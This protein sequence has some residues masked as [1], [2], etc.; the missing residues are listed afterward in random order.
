MGGVLP[1]ESAHRVR[2]P[3]RAALHHRQIAP[4]AHQGVPLI[5]KGPL[6]FLV[7]GEEEHAGGVPIQPVDDEHPAPGVALPHVVGGHAVGGAQLF[8]VAGHAQQPGG[9]VHHQDPAV[10]IE[11]WEG[12][13]G[14]GRGQH[15]HPLP[16]RQGMV[17]AGNRFPVHR[18]LAP[19]EQGLDVVAAPP[20]PLQQEGQQGAARL[21]RIFH[22]LHPYHILGGILS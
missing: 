20:D 12:G 18:H 6:G 10:L 5:L 7:P 9:L 4:A 19:G 14:P 8:P 2:L 17:V 11:H 22:F 1:Q 16:R 13:G 3:G 21:H 15:R